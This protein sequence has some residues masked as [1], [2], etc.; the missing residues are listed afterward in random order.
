MLRI[1]IIVIL[2]VAAAATPTAASTVTYQGQLADGGLPTAGVYDLRFTLYAEAAGGGALD[3]FTADRV[4]VL[5]G[6]FSVALEFSISLD[7]ST[8]WVEIAVRPAGSVG[9]FTPLAPR[10]RVTAAPFALSAPQA[11]TAVTAVSSVN[12]IDADTVDGHG[13]AFF[14][15]WTNRTGV[16]AELVDGDDDGLGELACASGEVPFFGDAGWICSPDRGAGLARTAVVGPVGTPSENGT[17]LL[18]AIAAVPTPATQADAWQVELEPGRYDLGSAGLELKPWLTLTGA[19]EKNTVITSSRCVSPGQ[20]GATITGAANASLRD[21]TVDNVCAVDTDWGC[22]IELPGD[23]IRLERVTARAIGT[24]KLNQAVRVQGARTWLERLSAT[25]GNA[26]RGNT[27]I[28]VYASGTTLV[29]CTGLS[30]N[31]S[32]LVLEGQ[33]WVRRGIFTALASDGVDRGVYISA[34]ADLHDV[35]AAGPDGAVLVIVDD[36]VLVTLSRLT[37]QGG[38]STQVNSGSLVVAIEH[39][40]IVAPGATIDANGGVVGV[41]ATQLWGDPV[42]GAVVCAGV[43]DEYWTFFSNLCP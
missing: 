23:D 38:V 33:S 8:L 4:A 19:G 10:Q 21:L 22:A 11:E 36:D 31:G 43:W 14:L 26:D 3:T 34:N 2:A 25:A 9:D 16:P 29:D 18:A 5:D 12:A 42:N 27:A 6:F 24:S 40:R 20:P 39:S 17:A 15:D 41:S 28:A 7:G 35:S 1:L 32:A 30:S 13:G 37:A